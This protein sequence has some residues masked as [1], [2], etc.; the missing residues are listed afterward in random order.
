[1]WVSFCV[2]KFC[3]SVWAVRAIIQQAPFVSTN[4]EQNRALRLIVDRAP[5]IKSVVENS[6]PF[7]HVSGLMSDCP[8]Q[9]AFR[10]LSFYILMY[11]NLW[12]SDLLCEHIKL[13]DA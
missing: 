8:L 13:G 4:V 10:G 3:S 1:M 9:A 6:L 7:I 5:Y 11:W 12:W 2:S